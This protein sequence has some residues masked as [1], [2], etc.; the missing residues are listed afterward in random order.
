[1]YVDSLGRVSY[2]QMKKHNGAGNMATPSPEKNGPYSKKIRAQW[3]DEDIIDSK[4]DGFMLGYEEAMDH[5]DDE[6]FEG[7]F[8]D[9]VD[10]IF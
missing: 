2:P 10:E 4:E 1:M 3:V 9:N 6:L 5:D 8:D 7:V